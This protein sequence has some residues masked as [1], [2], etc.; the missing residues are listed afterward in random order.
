MIQHVPNPETSIRIVLGSIRPCFHNLHLLMLP[1]VK[2][3]HCTNELQPMLVHMALHCRVLLATATP[4]CSTCVSNRYNR[5]ATFKTCAD[6]RTFNTA[7][8]VHHE[9]HLQSVY[10]SVADSQCRSDMPNYPVLSFDTWRGLCLVC[11]VR[12]SWRWHNPQ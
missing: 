9:G 4:S 2:S 8:P 3:M 7:C 10:S 1:N 5:L 6:A 12:N 11:A